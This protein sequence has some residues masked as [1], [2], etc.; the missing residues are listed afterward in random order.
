MKGTGRLVPNKEE[1]ALLRDLV[2]QGFRVRP[3]KNGMFI[4]SPDGKMCSALHFTPSDG[5]HKK[6]FEA[7]IRRMKRYARESRT[8]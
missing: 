1:D 8:I 2:E 7:D 6:N 4:Q 5:R 3:S